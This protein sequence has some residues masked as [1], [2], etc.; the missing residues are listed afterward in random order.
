[1]RTDSKILNIEEEDGKPSSICLGSLVC[2]RSA[3]HTLFEPGKLSPRIVWWPMCQC[4]LCP[5]YVRSS[6]VR[7]WGA[8][9]R[10]YVGSSSFTF[11]STLRHFMERHT[12]AGYVCGAQLSF[13][14]GSWG[15]RLPIILRIFG[16]D[17][18]DFC[19]TAQITWEIFLLRYLCFWLSILLTSDLEVI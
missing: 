8:S 12:I 3:P 18:T 9:Y 16:T 14:P 4:K 6:M 19:S 17:R 11:P 15:F 10:A 1:M 2:I 13:K 5:V 7:M